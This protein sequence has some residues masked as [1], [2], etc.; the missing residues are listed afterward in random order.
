MTNETPSQCN[1]FSWGVNLFKRNSDIIIPRHN[2]GILYVITTW[3]ITAML[4]DF[5]SKKDMNCYI[6]DSLRFASGGEGVY[7]SHSYMLWTCD[8]YMQQDSPYH[9]EGSIYS[10]GSMHPHRKTAWRP[11][12]TE[13][14]ETPESLWTKFTNLKPPMI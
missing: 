9:G 12:N 8:G 11:R 2:Y 10:I 6:V 13:Q 7:I 3:S 1:S 5:Y 14:N 4:L